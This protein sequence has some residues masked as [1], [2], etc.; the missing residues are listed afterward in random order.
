MDSGQFIIF[1]KFNDKA[2]ALELAGILEENSIA[3][4]MD[5]SSGY[6]PAFSNNEI[7]KEYSIKLQKA[8]FPRAEKLLQRISEKNILGI[9]NDHYLYGFTDDELIDI[10]YKEDEWSKEDFLLAK[11]ILKQRG[12]EINEADMKETKRQRIMELEKPE[13]SSK[14]WIFISYVLALMGG[15]LGIWIGW[16]LNTHK[17]TL[18]DGRQ[19]FSYTESDREHGKRIFFLGIFSFIAWI[20]VKVFL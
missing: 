7:A 19:V 13:K 3:F 1:R 5:D 18:P 8:D 14:S 10:V 2:L 6:D 17:K 15:L 12:R 4:E 11:K 20:C 9:K 16:H